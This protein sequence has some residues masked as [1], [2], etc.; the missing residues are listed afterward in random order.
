MVQKETR[1]RKM[2]FRNR[3][4]LVQLIIKENT[5]FCV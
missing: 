4:D 2:K 1:R 3:I 5:K